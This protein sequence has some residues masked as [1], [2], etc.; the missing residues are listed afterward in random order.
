MEMEP[1]GI[2]VEVTALCT[3][4]DH[5]QSADRETTITT[6]VYWQTNHV[7]SLLATA[8]SLIVL[9][10]EG[11]PARTHSLAVET[12]TP[13]KRENETDAYPKT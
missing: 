7:T 5:H 8:G 1:Y 6:Y 11:F 4:K 13:V 12:S 9:A 2:F 10:A 3:N